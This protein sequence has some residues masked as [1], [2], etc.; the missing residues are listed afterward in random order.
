[1][2]ERSMTLRALSVLNKCATEMFNDISENK[3]KLSEDYISI[4]VQT[5]VIMFC[6]GVGFCPGCMARLIASYQMGEKGKMIFNP[7]RHI[8]DGKLSLMDDDTV[9]V[10]H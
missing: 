4:T 9:E 5:F 7:C 3:D 8:E 2:E 1:M 6:I 10:Y